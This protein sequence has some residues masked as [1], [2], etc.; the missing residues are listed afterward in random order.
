MQ[1][2]T[3][4]GYAANL[5]SWLNQVPGVIYMGDSVYENKVSIY[6]DGVKANIGDNIILKDGKVSIEKA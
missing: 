4:T 3:V 6:V 5:P 2:Y 1:I